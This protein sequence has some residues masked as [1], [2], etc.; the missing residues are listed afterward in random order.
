MS[1]VMGV[2]PQPRIFAGSCGVAV[3]VDALGRVL[4]VP[5]VDVSD[6]KSEKIRRS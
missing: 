2:A 5:Y 1:P 6:F 3:P 4:C